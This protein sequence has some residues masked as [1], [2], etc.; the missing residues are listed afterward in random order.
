M[1]FF[2]ISSPTALPTSSDSAN[3]FAH[4]P[5]FF[6]KPSLDQ[7]SGDLGRRRQTQLQPIRDIRV[8]H[9]AIFAYI[10]KDIIPVLL[11]YFHIGDLFLSILTPLYFF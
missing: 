2:V 7:F 10:A 6:H 11:F 9:G 8:R 1:W 5:L 4:L 3:A